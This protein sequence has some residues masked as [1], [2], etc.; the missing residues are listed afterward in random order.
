MKILFDNDIIM[1]LLGKECNVFYYKI[2]LSDIFFV[3]YY[4]GKYK[5]YRFILYDVCIFDKLNLR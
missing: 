3:D 2:L 4:L 5:F 1:C